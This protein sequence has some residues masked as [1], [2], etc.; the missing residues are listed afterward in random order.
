MALMGFLNTGLAQTFHLEKPPPSVKLPRVLLDADVFREPHTRQRCVV[1][2]HLHGRRRTHSGPK[3]KNTMEPTLGRAVVVGRQ[4]LRAGQPRQTRG[5]SFVL[6]TSEGTTGT[7]L[8]LTLT[9]PLPPT[10]TTLCKVEGG[11]VY[12]ALSGGAFLHDGLLVWKHLS[13]QPGPHCLHRLS[14][15]KTVF[16]QNRTHNTSVPRAVNG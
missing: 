3:S 6:S 8:P 16:P 1:F 2:L 9:T 12:T 14:R 7:P 15:M 5:A 10:L 4:V 13:A 11:Y